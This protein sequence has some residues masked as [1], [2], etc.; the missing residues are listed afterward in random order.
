MIKEITKQE[1]NKLDKVVTYKNRTIGFLFV[2]NETE[3]LEKWKEAQFELG[4]AYQYQGDNKHIWDYYLAICCNF[5][6]D[7]L[8]AEVRFQIESDRFCCRKTFL[9][10]QSKKN[11]SEKDAIETI[12]P[13][14]KTPGKITLLKPDD[15]IS[16]MGTDLLKDQD[17]YTRV[18]DIKELDRL[19]DT[20]ILET[21][22]DG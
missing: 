17:F 11:F 12:F 14:I 5:D 1:L 15:L 19:A 22:A 9:F 16:K 18:W 13:T 21:S 3:L 10:K 6:E 4:S 2:A 7:T 20:L 8:G